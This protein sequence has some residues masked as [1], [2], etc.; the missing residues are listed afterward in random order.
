V[1]NK[2]KD[3]RVV[4]KKIKDEVNRKIIKNA[5]QPYLGIDVN[6]FL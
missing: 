5:Y 4:I 3:V 1:I 2:V 6:K